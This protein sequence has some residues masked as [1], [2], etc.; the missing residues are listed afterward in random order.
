M[1]SVQDAIAAA[2]AQ[3]EA[4]QQSQPVQQEQQAQQQAHVPVQSNVHAPAAPVM[5]VTD[6]VNNSMV[7]DDWLKVDKSTVSVGGH[8]YRR[9]PVIIRCADSSMGG[10]IQSFIGLN[11][12]NDNDAKYSKTFSNGSGIVDDG[13]NLGMSWQQHVQQVQQI[14]PFAKPFTGYQLLLEVAEETP[15]LDGNNP[16]SQGMLLGYATSKTSAKEVTKFLRPL[17]AGG[18]WGVPENL[19]LVHI[20]GKGQEATINGQKR[21]WAVLTIEDNGEYHEPE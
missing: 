18:V 6:A 12:G 10:S 14:Y 21:N 17:I 8:S 16:L 20:S 1:S 3:A 13:E 11:Y 19:R 15:D 4:N 9:I 7:V 5:S 2:K